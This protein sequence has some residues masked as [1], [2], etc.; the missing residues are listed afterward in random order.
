M[1]HSVRTGEHIGLHH[2]AKHL[3]HKRDAA[4]RLRI[5]PRHNYLLSNQRVPGQNVSRELESPQGLEPKFPLVLILKSSL[6]KPH[7]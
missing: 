7:I 1:I 3:T 5:F 4:L 6:M 2:V